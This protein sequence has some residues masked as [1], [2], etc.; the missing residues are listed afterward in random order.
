MN[1]YILDWVQLEVVLVNRQWNLAS[2][3]SKFEAHLLMFTLALFFIKFYNHVIWFSSPLHQTKVLRLLR[4]MMIFLHFF[5]FYSR[6]WKKKNFLSQEDDDSDSRRRGCFLHDSH[7]LFILVDNEEKK[8]YLKVCGNE[9]M[10]IFIYFAF[11]F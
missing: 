8:R 10:T 11:F 5:P 9:V 2:Y 7:D 4:L 1:I 6:K 3:F